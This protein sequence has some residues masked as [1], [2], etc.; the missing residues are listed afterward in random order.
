MRFRPEIDPCQ[1]YFF[2][3]KLFQRPLIKVCCK[4]TS[5]Q[6]FFLHHIYCAQSKVKWGGGGMVW[7]EWPCLLPPPPPH[8]PTIVTPLLLLLLIINQLF[9]G[10]V[11]D[12]ITKMCRKRYCQY[13]IIFGSTKSVSIKLVQSVNFWVYVQSLSLSLSVSF[14]IYITFMTVPIFNLFRH[15]CTKY[16]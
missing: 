8:D 2:S 4:R 16:V 12:F 6:W 13:R 7:M 9:V 11:Y 10:L 5:S 3:S 15:H 1:W 14:N